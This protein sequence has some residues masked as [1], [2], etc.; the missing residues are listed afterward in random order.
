MPV[1]GAHMPLSFFPLAL[2]RT[3]TSKH[4][5]NVPRPRYSNPVERLARVIVCRLGAYPSL[6]VSN[7]FVPPF[8]F[9]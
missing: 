5:K 6:D 7:L 9:L 8:M 2:P 3:L 4:Y 1:I